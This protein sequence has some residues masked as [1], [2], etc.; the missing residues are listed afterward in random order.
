MDNRVI[1]VAFSEFFGPESSNTV[2]AGQSKK[3]FLISFFFFEF[4]NVTRVCE[5]GV[6]R[7]FY[8]RPDSPRG[9]SAGLWWSF[10]TNADKTTLEAVNANSS[11]MYTIRSD[12]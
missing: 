8:V 6:T 2:R 4:V 3:T 5:T 7:C 12:T 9:L 1:N 10:K 11:I